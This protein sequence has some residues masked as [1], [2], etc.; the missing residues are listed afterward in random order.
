MESGLLSVTLLFLLYKRD[1][2]IETRRGCVPK[3]TLSEQDPRLGSDS[4]LPW[5]RGA[6][7]QAELNILEDAV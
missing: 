6:G 3:L 1:T 2:E 4:P 5:Q 7:N